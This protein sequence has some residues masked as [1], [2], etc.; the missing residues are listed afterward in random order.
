M[1]FEIL[2]WLTFA[3]WW[4]FSA[5]MWRARLQIPKQQSAAPITPLN[6]II[7]RV[8]QILLLVAIVTGLMVCVGWVE[9]ETGWWIVPGGLLA[10]LGVGGIFYC[11]NHLGRFWTVGA[12]VQTEHQ[13]IDNGPYAVV[14]HPIYASVLLFFFGYTLVFPAWWMIGIALILLSIYVYWIMVEDNF[15]AENLPGYEAYREKVRYRLVPM[16]W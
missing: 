12:I 13:V 1:I 3:L 11:G 4:G 2:R 6:T 9:L 8:F 5:A 14:R 16:I 15:L 10:M 7:G